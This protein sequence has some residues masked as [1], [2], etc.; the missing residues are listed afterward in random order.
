[1][2]FSSARTCVEHVDYNAKLEDQWDFSNSSE[3][4]MFNFNSDF[5]LD[6][7]NKPVSGSLSVEVKELEELPEQWRRSKLAWL[8]KELPA[9][10]QG[11][12]V[13]VLNAQRKWVTQQDAT[14]LA[15][16]CL[17]I[18]ENETAFRVKFVSH[19]I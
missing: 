11:V 8:C 18:R 7:M 1:M 13:R 19:S 2:A 9:H 4:D 16:H 12:L 10:K 6:E 15:V 3:K 5:G 17:R 14:Y